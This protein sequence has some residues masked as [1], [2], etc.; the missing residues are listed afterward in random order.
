MKEIVNLVR[1]EDLVRWST[2]HDWFADSRLFDMLWYPEYR[3]LGSA[4]LFAF[5]Q[6]I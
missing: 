3:P 6:N 4:A 1:K 2:I 5:M